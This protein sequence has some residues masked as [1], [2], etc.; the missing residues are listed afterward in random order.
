MS[1]I[2][3]RD[4]SQYHRFLPHSV[5]RCG[6]IF[7]LGFAFCGQNVLLAH[8]HIPVARQFIIII[9]IIIII[10][11]VVIIIIIISDQ[12]GL[13]RPVSASSNGLFKGLLFCNGKCLP[14]KNELQ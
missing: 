5:F 10:I 13:D 9:I 3:I 12:L 8:C 4:A 7:V 2:R 6:V 11:V 14:P 1:F